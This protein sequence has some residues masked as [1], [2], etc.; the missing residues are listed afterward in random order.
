[1][2]SFAPESLACYKPSPSVVARP[3]AED[4]V[5]LDLASGIYFSLNSVGAF[6]WQEISAGKTPSEVAQT[7]A[8]T[9]EVCP[10]TATADVDSFLRTLLSQG[11]IAPV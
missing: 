9:Y 3:I 5:L 1:M 6:I 7:I 11:L 10:T 2:Q 8:D 4:T